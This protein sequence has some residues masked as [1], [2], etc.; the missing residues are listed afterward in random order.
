MGQME[1]LIHCLFLKVF[2]S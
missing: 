2:V 1:L